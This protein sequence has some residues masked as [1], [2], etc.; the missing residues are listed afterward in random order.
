MVGEVD[1]RAL[2]WMEEADP[3]VE[4]LGVA[5]NQWVASVYLSRS[6]LEDLGKWSGLQGPSLELRDLGGSLQSEAP[7]NPLDRSIRL[8]VLPDEG[9]PSTSACRLVAL[10]SWHCNQRRY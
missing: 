8:V 9:R 1:P 3:L 2:A 5:G 6:Q 4:H 10:P 7:G